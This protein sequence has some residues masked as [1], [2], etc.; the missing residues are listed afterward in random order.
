MSKA[1]NAPLDALADRIMR[2]VSGPMWHGPALAELLAGITAREAA[3]HPVAEAHSIWELV[4][5]VTTWSGIVRERLHSTT[6][7]DATEEQDWPRVP[8]PATAAAW[9]DATARLAASYDALAAEVR[10]LPPERLR[11]L[12]PG[13]DTSI[14]DML[15]GVVEHGTYHGGQIALLARALGTR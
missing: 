13:R 2:T 8:A 4:L 3:E 15:H 7:V 9:R 12:V 10:A 11:E 1:M 14:G 5:H 6:P